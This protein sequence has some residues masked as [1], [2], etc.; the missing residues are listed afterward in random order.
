MKNKGMVLYCFSPPIMLATF[1]IEMLLAGYT[2]IKSRQNKSDLFIVF[3]LVFL[4]LFQ[5]A[6][7]QICEGNNLLLWARLGLIVI[8]FL[9]VLGLYLIT[10][11]NKK[12]YLLQIGI[13][14]AIAFTTVIL[15]IPTA[16]TNATCDGNYIIFNTN[17]GIFSFYGYYYFGFLILGLFESVKGIHNNQDK[18]P[19]KKA[20]K[21]FIVGYLSFVLPLTAV[22]LVVPATRMAVELIMCGFAIIFAFI[23]TFKIAPIYYT[24]VNKVDK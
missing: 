10:R 24:Y 9:P 14:L 15:L 16:V 13:V 11:L 1:I 21:W 18:E 19:L 3:T 12:T 8:T 6:E 17:F 20:F 5:L 7:Y 4:A 2:Y 22:Y 23:L